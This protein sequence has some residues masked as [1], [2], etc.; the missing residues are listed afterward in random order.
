SRGPVV[1]PPGGPSTGRWVRGRE[2][3]ELPLDADHH[4]LFNPM[5]GGGAVVVNEPARRI[6]HAFDRPATLDSLSSTFVDLC[7]DL[8]AAFTRLGQLEMIRPEMLASRLAC[9]VRRI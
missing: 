7:P 5:G 2:V 6:L 4:V 8:L 3:I 9:G 1:E